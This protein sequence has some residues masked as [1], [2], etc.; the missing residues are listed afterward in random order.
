MA[1]ERM[2]RHDAERQVSVS[3][4][5]MAIFR[6][7]RLCTNP[8]GI[9]GNEGISWF[10]PLPFILAAQ[11]KGNHGIFI[12]TA[13]RLDDSKKLA[14]RLWGEVANHFLDNRARDTHLVPR[15]C[16]DEVF[17]QGAATR[18]GGTVRGRR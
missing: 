16:V 1:Q 2:S 5:E 17:D 4:E 7:Q 12:D 10:Q 9:G 18:L 6:N 14:R 15:R 3:G 8:F 13:Q 11:L